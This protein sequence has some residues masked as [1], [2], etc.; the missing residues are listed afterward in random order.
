[1]NTTLQKLK[2]DQ[3]SLPIHQLRGD[4]QTTE[5]DLSSP[6]YTDVYTRI[7][8]FLVK[9]HMVDC[10][11]SRLFFLVAVAVVYYRNHIISTE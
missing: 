2:I 4:G 3:V 10:T 6:E 8:A 9:V 7:I 5:L 1:M 11:S